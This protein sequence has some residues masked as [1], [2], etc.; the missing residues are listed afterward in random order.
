MKLF[1]EKGILI[2]CFLPIVLLMTCVSLLTTN[3]YLQLSLDKYKSHSSIEFDKEFVSE[4]IMGYL[5]YKYPDL[6]FGANETDKTILLKDIEIRHMKDVLDV[7]TIL[8]IVGFLSLILCVLNGYYLWKRNKNKLYNTLKKVWIAPSIL[9]SI[10]GVACLIDFDA[11]FTLFHQIAFRNNDWILSYND[12]LIQLLPFDF[13]LVSTILL[14]SLFLI[15]L[16]SLALIGK[17]K[18]RKL[19]CTFKRIT[20]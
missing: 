3:L 15:S 16:F 6:Y 7:F 4:K 17:Y 8:R 19:K 18:E 11:L 12:A 20:K 5:N 10:I 13:W 14:I 1:K 2:Y 9:I